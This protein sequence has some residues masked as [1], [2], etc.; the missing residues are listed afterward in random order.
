MIFP[1]VAEFRA[2]GFTPRVAIIGS[3]PA[4]ISIARVLDKANIPCVILEAGSEEVTEESQ[5]FYKGK[6]VG[7]YYFDLDVTRIR[8]FGGCSKHQVLGLINR[9]DERSSH[10]PCG[11][12]Y[13]NSDHIQPLLNRCWL[14]LPG[15]SSSPAGEKSDVKIKYSMVYN[16]I[17]T[18]FL[19]GCRDA[20]FYETLIRVRDG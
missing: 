10:A 15:F 11:A 13:R 6:T 7:D 8:L 19:G 5:D 20:T 4:G 12:Y 16:I 14:Y 1:G 18:L 17:L 9:F 3:G 2:S